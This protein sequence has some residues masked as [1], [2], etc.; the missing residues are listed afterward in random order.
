MKPA[1]Q[2]LIKHLEYLR[3]VEGCTHVNVAAESI[4]LLRGKLGIKKPTPVKEA[5]IPLPVPIV[6]K[7]KPKIL[8]VSTSTL[9]HQNEMLADLGKGFDSKFVL[10]KNINLELPSLFMAMEAY[11]P[12]RIVFLSPGLSYWFGGTDKAPFTINSVKAYYSTYWEI[13]KLHIDAGVW[14][15][16]VAECGN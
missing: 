16:F 6:T 5:V 11:R 2:A 14:G 1:L 4:D 10:I 3:D 12:E 7:A 9:P 15:L 13:F 8:F